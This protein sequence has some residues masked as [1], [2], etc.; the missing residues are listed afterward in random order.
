MPMPSNTVEGWI[1]YANNDINTAVFMMNAARNPRPYEIILH[2]CHQCAEKM[3]KAFLLHNAG[4]YPMSHN[5]K[6]LRKECAG[7]DSDFN[8][9]RVVEHCVYLDTF[10]NV[11]YPDFTIS[12]DASHAKRGINSAKRIQDFVSMKLRQG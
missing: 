3:L 5:L 11:K 8:K 1:R 10:W 7:I 2:H 12:I 4:G 9:R 6:E